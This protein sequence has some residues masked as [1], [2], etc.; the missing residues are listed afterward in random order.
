LISSPSKCSPDVARQPIFPLLPPIESPL[1]PRQAMSDGSRGVDVRRDC[2]KS[3]TRCPSR[4]I[5]THCSIA[6]S[7]W[8]DYWRTTTGAQEI[9]NW[10]GTARHNRFAQKTCN[11]WLWFPFVVAPVRCAVSSA[12]D[13]CS[14]TTFPGSSDY[15]IIFDYETTPDFSLRSLPLLL[16]GDVPLRAFFNSA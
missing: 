1:E 13:I 11:Y 10:H 15:S 5:R 3:T 4:P 2:R 9:R 12:T 14:G 7:V 6:T 16:P 8:I